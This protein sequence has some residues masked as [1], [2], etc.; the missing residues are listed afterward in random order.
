MR[1]SLRR[2]ALRRWIASTGDLPFND[3]ADIAGEFKKKIDR[4]VASLPNASLSF[5]SRDAILKKCFAD[6]SGVNLLHC[7]AEH[8][9]VAIVEVLLGDDT[10]L[11]NDSY[12]NTADDDGRIPIH[13]AAW[14]CKPDVVKVLIERGSRLDVKTKSG[15][16]PLHYCAT[17]SSKEEALQCAQRLLNAGADFRVRNGSGQTPAALAAALG[18]E[19]FVK[20]LLRHKQSID[21]KLSERDNGS[22]A[23]HA[24]GS[25]AK[26]E[27][28]ADDELK[29]AIEEADKV[30]ERIRSIAAEKKKKEL[31]AQK[32]K[33][34]PTKPVDGFI[35]ADTFQG[36]KRG[37]TFRRVQMVRDTIR[38]QAR[39]RIRIRYPS[40]GRLLLSSLALLSS[41]VSAS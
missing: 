21:A 29:K 2:T 3:D 40:I 37:F 34:L 41:W 22:A 10:D 4:L 24:N 8:G 19:A 23:A 26:G 9:A 33:D 28:V 27:Q 36:N 16:T 25:A 39:H 6:A 12:V 20:L 17:G 35:P 30:R 15:F 13:W 38:I 5:S 32:M 31:E 14:K 1:K 11:P 18:R 7:A